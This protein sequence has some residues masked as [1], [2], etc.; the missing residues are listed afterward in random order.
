ML[1]GVCFA[2]FAYQLYLRGIFGNEE[3]LKLEWGFT[4]TLK[5]AGP[6]SFFVLAGAFVVYVTFVG[7]LTSAPILTPEEF[8]KLVALVSTVVAHTSSGNGE[9]PEAREAHVSDAK[10]V[11]IVKKASEGRPLDD[12]ERVI[13]Q[14]WVSSVGATQRGHTNEAVPEASG[15]ARA[16]RPAPP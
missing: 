6:G 16:T 14:D 3:D 13:L 11:T 7:G 12:S 10:I 15:R 4:L 2:Y 8:E 5:K 1:T 9:I